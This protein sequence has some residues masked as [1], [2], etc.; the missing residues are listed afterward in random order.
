[1][2]WGDGLPTEV[3]IALVASAVRAAAVV[4]FAAVLLAAARRATA[5]TRLRTWTA[6]LVVALAMPALDVLVPIW[7]LP[8]LSEPPRATFDRVSPARWTSLPV[9][10][11]TI[12]APVATHLPEVIA[13]PVRKVRSR[14]PSPAAIVL[15]IYA[16]VTALILARVAR[17]WRDSLRLR[18]ESRSVDD[19]RLPARLGSAARVVGV[20]RYP[21]ILS[22]PRVCVPCAVGV[23]RP[24][25]VLPPDWREWNQATLEA[26]LRHEFAHI[27]RADALVQRLAL[28]HLAIF[29]FSPLSWWLVRRVVTL[30]EEA[31]DDEV[32]ASGTDPVSY[33]GLLLSFASGRRMFIA[34]RVSMANGADVEKRLERILS[35][36][37]RR[38]T[39]R[40][41]TLA[42]TAVAIGAMLPIGVAAASIHPIAVATA[43]GLTPAVLAAPARAVLSGASPVEAIRLA[44]ESAPSN[45]ADA[46]I[47]APSAEQATPAAHSSNG[48]GMT[49]MVFDLP[50]LPGDDLARAIG[51]ARETVRQAAERAKDA[52]A[53][54][55][56]F[57]V[58]TIDRAVTVTEDF[59]NDTRRLDAAFDRLAAVTPVPAPAPSAPPV[60]ASTGALTAMQRELDRLK[61][62]GAALRTDAMTT[63]CANIAAAQSQNALAARDFYYFN[64]QGPAGPNAPGVIYFSNG[65]Q[66]GLQA[67]RDID[68]IAN[69]CRTAPR[70][71]AFRWTGGPGWE[72]TQPTPSV[73]QNDAEALAASVIVLLFDLS[74]VPH[75][76]AVATIDRARLVVEQYQV[77]ASVG[78]G[79][80]PLF[81][82]GTLGK[83][84]GTLEFTGDRA[85]IFAALDKL[86]AESGAPT[87]AERRQSFQAACRQ[88][89]RVYAD[90]EKFLKADPMYQAAAQIGTAR[91][92]EAVPWVY[93]SGTNFETGTG[94][95]RFSLSAHDA[96]DTANGLP[97][98]GSS[99]QW[100][101]FVTPIGPQRPSLAWTLSLA[102]RP[103]D[104]P[105]TVSLA[106][107]KF[108]VGY[109]S[110]HVR[111]DSTKTIR[112]ITLA[113]LVTT[114]AG[115][116]AQRFSRSGPSARILP[117]ASIDIASAI[118][119]PASFASL[120]AQ[121]ASAV[122]KVVT[123]EFEDGTTW[124]SD[125]GRK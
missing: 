29:W 23:V 54:D 10:S 98:A 24:A 42:A 122:V 46:S 62:E 27:A 19:S 97:K 111:N 77:R 83:T 112:S 119:D 124:T 108:D 66:R 95:S 12:V 56:L 104:S 59:T 22:H 9:V 32:L 16:L 45:P 90:A 61:R 109:V 79:R 94:V 25:V 20:G 87:A 71:V 99:I 120:G 115:A 89:P 30:G 18:R 93:Y 110:L 49:V 91:N 80:I 100:L 125:I 65:V 96:C 85:R 15:S 82:V 101:N 64:Y 114:R 81:A 92:W 21:R 48:Q 76:H 78:L 3:L 51:A 1:V 58:M 35:Y 34:S 72:P 113:A 84:P 70:P 36:T 117:G 105:V 68:N 106:S 31:S 28:L 40:R 37:E 123:V 88:I 38:P 11:E 5:E 17:G 69:A 107:P 75:D 67:G 63:I 103:S 47:L 74:E 41:R 6:V 13:S 55:R 4:A 53:P 44:V 116:P 60:G 8:V 86:L 118:I 73:V 33:A 26:V 52:N 121:D 57:G 39:L 14:L 43:R 7:R 50:S 102:D 2:S